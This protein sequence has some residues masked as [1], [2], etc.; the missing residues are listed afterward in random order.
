ML[1]CYLNLVASPLFLY[2]CKEQF[3][4]FTIISFVLVF[5]RYISQDPAK[6]QEGAK[7]YH[8]FLHSKSVIG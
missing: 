8:G 7:N 5:M 2:H 4:L 3:F 1:K 6:Y